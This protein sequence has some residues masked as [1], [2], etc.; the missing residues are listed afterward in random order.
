MKARSRVSV[1]AA[2]LLMTGSMAACGSNAAGSGA[3]GGY[4]AAP[5]TTSAPA[6]APAAAPGASAAVTVG[7]SSSKLG[8]I[9]VDGRG[10]TLYLFT[11]DTRGSGASTCEGS[12]LAAWPPLLGTPEAGSGADQARLGTITRSDGAIQ[13]TY[14]GWPLY[15]WAQDSAPGDTNG[16][17]VNGVWWMVS[18][19][20]EPVGSRSG[21]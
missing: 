15:Y 14:N 5:G 3:G 11:K 6:S 19:A 12:C 1:L 4:G 17:G 9:L 13:V 8:T 20:G 21:A 16:Q 18:P 2:T 7:T 10:M